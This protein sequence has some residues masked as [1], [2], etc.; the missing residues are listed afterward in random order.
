[1]P[2]FLRSNA[3]RVFPFTTFTFVSRP[4]ATICDKLP[5]HLGGALSF[6]AL[7]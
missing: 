3:Y 2:N 4:S 6:I 1:M 7:V 5:I